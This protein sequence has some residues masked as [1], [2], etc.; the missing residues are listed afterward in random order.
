MLNFSQRQGLRPIKTQIQKEDIDIDLRNALWNG[1][2]LFYLNRFSGYVNNAKQPIR[3]LAHRLW[4]DYYKNRVDE[5]PDLH[6]LAQKIKN[7]FLNNPWNEVYD[8]L[9]YIPNNYYD[10]NYGGYENSANSEFFKY[11]NSHLEKHLSAYRFVDKLIVEISS[12]IEIK[13]IENALMLPSKY[14]NVKVHLRRSLELLSD[15]LT[16]D[17]RNSIKESISAVEA[18]SCII[19]DNPK[20]TLGQA[21]KTIEKGGLLHTALK[22]S[23]SSLY[24]YTSDADGIRHCLLDESALKQEDALYMLISCSSF[25]NYLTIKFENQKNNGR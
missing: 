11:S 12:E 10:E 17:Y 1:L 20:A 21:L 4:V 6:N 19:A 24:G 7:D 25:I 15:R 23:F 8:I 3:F 22:T 9:E 2:S 5:L 16:P 13:S 18:V 14:E